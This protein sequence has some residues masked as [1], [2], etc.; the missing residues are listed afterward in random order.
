[1]HWDM[2]TREGLELAAG[3]YL[4]HVKDHLTG[5]EKLGKIAILK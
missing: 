5:K 4:Y 2:L 1:V 3:V